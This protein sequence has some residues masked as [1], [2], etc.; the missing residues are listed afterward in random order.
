VSLFE[1]IEFGSLFFETPGVL[2]LLAVPPVCAF[3]WWV[4]SARSPFAYPADARAF[5]VPATWRVRLRWLTAA[6]R[7]LALT[8]LIIAAA[9]PREGVGNV[10]TVTNGVAI[11]AAIDRSYSMTDGMVLDGEQTT[12]FE[13]V[14][15]VFREFVAG[16]GED[17]PGREGDLI[18]IVQFAR[19]ADTQAPPIRTRETLLTILDN[20]E[21]APYTMLEA[22]TSIGDAIAL[23]AARLESVETQLGAAET[24][25]GDPDAPV[26]LGPALATDPDFVINSKIII[27]L[28]DG[29][30][31]S[32][33]TRA[34]EA[35]ALC[36]EWGIKVYCIGI[37]NPGTR[38]G[39]DEDIPKRIAEMTG[40]LYRRAT[41]ADS[42][43]AVYA[44]IDALEKTEVQQLDYTTYREWFWLPAFAAALLLAL[45]LGFSTLVL[46]RAA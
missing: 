19:L 16:N 8:L 10:R 39:F 44:E 38:F 32:G 21:L 14:K 35:A 37:G 2:L 40:G 28:T 42:L 13:A 24:G 11:M 27:L 4:R 22:G 43:R 12:R 34:L 46:R 30:E 29:D 1:E 3:V 9:R 20:L 33:R 23:A 31:R 17:L 26:D 15:R 7:L 5:A 6:L 18:G 25:P 41:D 36:R 45:E